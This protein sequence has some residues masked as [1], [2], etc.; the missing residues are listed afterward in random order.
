MT[1]HA[2]RAPLLAAKL[3]ALVR[4]RWGEGEGEAARPRVAGSLPGGATLLAGQRLWALL[5]DD[6]TRRLGSVL[7][8]ARRR[9]ATEVDVLVDDPDD[10]AVVARRASMFATPVTVW[11]IEGR[12]L[13]PAEPAPVAARLVPAPEAE[14]YR[15][16][17]ARA[18]LDVVEER[19]EIIG[20]VLGLEVAR[21]VVD[22]HGARVEAGVGRFDREA[23]AMMFG[24]LAEADAL[25]R[26]ADVVRE[27]RRPGAA[28]HPL[29]QLVPERWLRSLIVADP[30]VVGATV[31]AP[32]ESALPRRNLKEQSVATAVG[33]GPSGEPV[34][35]VCSTGVDLELVPAAADDRL[36]HAPGAR[37]VLVVPAADA[38]PV[39][40]EL[41]QTLV[42]PAEIVA[43]PA[44]W[45]EGVRVGGGGA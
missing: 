31:L 39:A 13:R 8:V 9:G 4:E 19:G 32:V 38:L 16:V 45:R 3:A 14:L 2:D 34:V 35:V 18:G 27:I 5:D 40:T 33:H 29:N 22:A 28:P 23:G 41:S 37:L 15:P 1:D 12:T 7:A 42:D 26:A 44:G 21:V 25:Q 30:T 36:A 24:H 6:P 11:S 17:L 43:V 20:E 10:A